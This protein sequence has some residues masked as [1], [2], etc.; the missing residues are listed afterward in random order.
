MNRYITLDGY[1]YA[2]KQGT[3]IRSWDRSF[4]TT[5]ASNLIRMNY[6]DRG[7]GVE[8][9]SMT[10]MVASWPAGSTLNNDGIIQTADQQMLNLE[11][12]Y[13]KVASAL[14]FLDPYGNAPRRDFTTGI[15]FSDLKQILP[16]YTSSAK[17]YY[18]VEI[19]LIEAAGMQIT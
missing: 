8:T 11:T 5:L 17:S 14:S 1:K 3:Y 12:S 4:T 9:Y 15:I 6:V 2:I 10:L 19:T 7:P 16:N 18:E 13:L